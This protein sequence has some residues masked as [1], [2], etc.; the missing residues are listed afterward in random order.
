MNKSLNELLGDMREVKILT[1]EL[2]TSFIAFRSQL[3]FHAQP[4]VA[5][6]LRDT[7]ATL[8]ELHKR[9]TTLKNQ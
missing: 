8:L 6:R 9:I 2:V 4:H 5:E 7:F 1:I 3:F